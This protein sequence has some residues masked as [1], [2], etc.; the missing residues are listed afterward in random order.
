MIPPHPAGATKG[1]VA[2]C[3][4]E[5]LKWTSN[6]AAGNSSFLN[7]SNLLKMF[8]LNK[9][10][11]SETSLKAPRL[12]I[13]AAELEGWQSGGGRKEAGLQSG[14]LLA[15]MF[16]KGMSDTT[17]PMSTSTFGSRNLR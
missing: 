12:P 8:D 17:T 1:S 6:L 5:Q 14:A 15:H 9:P 13:L 11:S 7:A 4:A 2:I 3:Y 16:G 10:F